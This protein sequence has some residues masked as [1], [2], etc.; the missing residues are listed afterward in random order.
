MIV[1]MYIFFQGKERKNEGGKI[2][3]TK[4]EK[5]KRQSFVP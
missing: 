3:R 5:K 2:A 4:E 1:S